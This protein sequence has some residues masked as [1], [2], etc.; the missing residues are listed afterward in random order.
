MWVY[1]KRNM[2]NVSSINFLFTVH[3]RSLTGYIFEREKL[4]NKKVR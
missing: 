2:V 1:L 4:R 3:K